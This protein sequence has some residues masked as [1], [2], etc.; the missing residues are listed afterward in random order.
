MLHCRSEVSLRWAGNR[1]PE[2]N[3]LT[4]SLANFYKMHSSSTE[5]LA[6]YIENIPTSFRKIAKGHN[7]KLICLEFVVNIDLVRLGAPRHL[8][9]HL[10]PSKYGEHM[11]R[12]AESRGD[13][14]GLVTN[15]RKR[16][17]SASASGPAA[18]NKRLRALNTTSGFSRNAG[19][20]TDVDSTDIGSL[21]GSRFG[22]TTRAST[23]MQ[24]KT[25]SN[26]T[27]EWFN[28]SIDPMTLMP[29]VFK[30]SAL[31]DALISDQHFAKG[32]SKIA[33][34]VRAVHCFTGAILIFSQMIIYDSGTEER[35]V[36]KRMYRTSDEDSDSL[37]NT[38]SVGENRALLEVE[39]VRPAVGEKFWGDFVSYAMEMDVPIFLR[40]F[41]LLLK[42]QAGA[43][44][45]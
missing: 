39:C 40:A 31:I 8:T 7:S 9:M 23:P 26:V 45:N 22:A 33:F 27:L 4:G 16:T 35:V 37:T 42:L 38:I 32:A 30:V 2:P 21:L 20:D 29:E 43:Q 17:V 13:D 3:S 15:S 44:F 1:L 11:E 14:E 18:I 6:A 25:Q 12:D 36:A 19:V 41:L 24:P 34:D 5:K 10:H 28:V